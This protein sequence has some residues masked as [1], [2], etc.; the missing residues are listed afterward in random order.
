[1]ITYS[2]YEYGNYN[3]CY[4]MKHSIAMLSAF[5]METRIFV[6]VLKNCIWTCNGVK[7]N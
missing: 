5:K 7:I 1:M 6:K 4:G 3:L 2:Y